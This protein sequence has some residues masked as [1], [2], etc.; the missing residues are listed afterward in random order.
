MPGVIEA[1]KTG[2][3]KCRGCGQAIAAGTLRLGERV[4]NPFSDDGGETTLW[5]HVACAAFLRPEA[6]LEVLA[7]P[8]TAGVAAGIDGRE[9][10]A[11][12]AALGAAHRR[13]PR[14]TAAERASTG[15]ATCRHCKTLIEK[16]AWRLALTYYDEGRFAPSGFIHLGC[17]R[18]YLETVEIFGRL[19]HFSPA[20]TAP[21]LEEIRQLLG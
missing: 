14:A 12:E 4:P 19:R 2:R 8:E 13:L 7:A 3:A 5:Y 9:R 20:L 1:A 16:G 10:L 6:F 17:A 15:R 11:Q 18:E 21:E